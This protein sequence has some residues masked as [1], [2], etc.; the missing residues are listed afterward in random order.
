MLPTMITVA[1]VI[2]VVGCLNWAK[3]VLIPVAFAV[4]LSFVLSPVIT[5]LQRRGLP[6]ATAVVA[7]VL[8]TS[9]CVTAFGWMLGSQFVHLAEQLPTYQD[10]VARRIAEVREQ[11][12][13][14]LLGKVQRFVDRI[15]VAA[16]EPIAEEVTDE[17]QP[18][19]VIG[20]NGHWTI[21]PWVASAGEA[22]GFLVSAGLVLMLVV[23]MLLHRE[24]VRNRV[25]RLFGEG[26]MTVTTK[27][28]DDAGKRISRFLLAQ[29]SLNGAFGLFIT[30]GLWGI[31]V[32]Y[33]LVWGFLAAC[34]RY[35]PYIG[36]WVAAILPLSL[37]LLT[38]DGW[39]QPLT[40]V[41]LFVVFELISNLILEPWLYGQSIGV[42]QAALLVALTFWTWLWGPAG[43]VL[44]APLTV[45]LVVLGK[46]VPA[47]KFFD[48]ILGDTPA[49][50]SDVKF[51]Q[52]LLARDQDEAWELVRDQLRAE[53][54]EQ[55]LDQTVIPALIQMKRDLEADRIREGE[56]EFI[57][58]TM[59][60]I[61]EDQG[62]SKPDA[63]EVRVPGE[64]VLRIVA[65]PAR[66]IADETALALFGRLLDPK[67]CRMEIVSTERLV[68]EVV[69]MIA[70]EKPSIVC[71]AAL[72][73][74][75]LAHTRL[76]CKRLR[77]H[78][79]ELKIVAGR[80]G[81]RSGVD[82]DREQLLSAGA[83]HFGTTMQETAAQLVQ[84]AE[85]FCEMKRGSEE[86]EER[87]EALCAVED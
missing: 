17:P 20:E 37:S 74:G 64:G 60:E 58:Q 59:R 7:V 33:S 38:A 63:E 36:P 27:A 24:D 78:F 48:I 79:P 9:L 87:A 55:V 3:P 26:R 71:V 22:V 73:T 16:T 80:W 51:Y 29:L 45:C 84:I 82:S 34:L 8:A 76:L 77:R 85:N 83:N 2:L 43:L 49:L 31:G 57:L 12:K 25:L 67:V 70:D 53:P 54:L 42:S 40:V 56:A 69:E 68:S 75:G 86:A 15:T 4:L 35:F 39:G 6:R 30:L 28:L 1:S 14:S 81:L 23:L 41:A 10:N 66:D 50:T 44:A 62:G 52:R 61:V 19:K 5:S 18:V 65:Y 46:Y 72:P 11:G 21:G 47:L 13:D 32:P